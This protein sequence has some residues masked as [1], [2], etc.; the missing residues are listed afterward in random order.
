MK[1]AMRFLLVL[2]IVSLSVPTA[3]AASYSSRSYGSSYYDYTDRY[4]GGSRRTYAR[5]YQDG[6]VDGYDDGY[7]RGNT[8]NDGYDR[9]GHRYTRYYDSSYYKPGYRR[10]YYESYA[11]RYYYGRSHFVT[12]V[13]NSYMRYY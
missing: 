6:Y 9:Y 12:T 11:P 2:L 4:D 10:T 7:R 3:F 5:G 1:H 8:Y 13:R